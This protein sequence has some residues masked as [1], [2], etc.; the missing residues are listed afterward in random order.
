MLLLRSIDSLMDLPLSPSSVFAASHA[1][2]CNPAQKPH[3]PKDW[4]RAS[5]AHTFAESAHEKYQDE[6]PE[7]GRGLGLCNGG[8]LVVEP[9]KEYYDLIMETIN[10]PAATDSY[11]FADQSLLS[12]VF[13]GRWLGLSYTYN[14]LKTMRWC[15]KELWRD[16]EVRNVHYILSPK[17]W[18]ETEEEKKAEGRDETHKW[19]WEANEE[20]KREER[21]RG[22]VDEW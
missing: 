11:D 10:Q 22:I 14:A 4:V 5:C 13:K 6:G 21:E 8:L 15:H 18:D 17:P 12:D 2:T 3:Y 16:E 7:C 19:W 20:R 9:R 1:C